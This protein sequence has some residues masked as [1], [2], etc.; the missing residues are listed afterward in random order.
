MNPG[1][2]LC[3]AALKSPPQYYICREGFSTDHAMIC[4]HGGSL[5]PGDL[6]NVRGRVTKGMTIS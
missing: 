5:V 4:S 6:E 1:F 2:S 3:M